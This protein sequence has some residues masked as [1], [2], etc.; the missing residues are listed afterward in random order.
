LRCRVGLS[1]RSAP[2]RFSPFDDRVAPLFLSLIC[3]VVCNARAQSRRSR[4]TLVLRGTTI[5]GSARVVNSSGKDFP[6]LRAGDSGRVE[7]G[8]NIIVLGS[9]LGLEVRYRPALSAGNARSGTWRC[10]RSLH[11][12]LLEVAEGLSSIHMGRSWAHPSFSS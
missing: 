12:Y 11:P 7:V 1:H 5:S 6:V 9:P 2:G 4:T 10:S 3:W 8:E